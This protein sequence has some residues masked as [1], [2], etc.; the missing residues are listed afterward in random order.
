M[1]Q[2]KRMVRISSA[3]KRVRCPNIYHVMCIPKTKKKAIYLY[4][5]P[6]PP[7]FILL[8]SRWRVWAVTIAD[9]I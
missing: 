6:L 8:N 2:L 7:V 5:L 9:V 3:I 1:T 4:T